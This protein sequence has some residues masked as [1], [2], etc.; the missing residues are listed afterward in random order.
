MLHPIK[1]KHPNKLHHL[2][3]RIHQLLELLLSSMILIPIHEAHR[4]EC[5]VDMGD[6]GILVDGIGNFMALADDSGDLVGGVEDVLHAVYIAGGEGNDEVIDPDALVLSEG[7][8]GLGHLVGGV[9]DVSVAK[10]DDAIGD[11]LALG[12]V[13]DQIVAGGIVL[14]FARCIYKF[15]VR[16]SIKL[17]Y[18]DWALPGYCR[19]GMRN[20][21]RGSL[22]KCSF[23]CK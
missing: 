4:I 16:H 1:R 2:S 21:S 14:V 3:Q 17:L 6:P 23:I 20:A 5:K 18:F 19:K 8:G 22:I 12:H 7:S 11:F 10:A 9:G 15:Y 13:M